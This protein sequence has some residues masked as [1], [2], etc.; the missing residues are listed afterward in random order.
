[1][2][3]KTLLTILAI[4]AICAVA[5]YNFSHN[6]RTEEMSDLMLANIEAL[7]QGESGENYYV[8]TIIRTE[9]GRETIIIDGGTYQNCRKSIIT[10]CGEG[11]LFCISGVAYDDCHSVNLT[12]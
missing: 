6:L 2:K 8:S 7:T 3:T 9:D 12:D 11:T 10:C 4:I 1:M 5:K